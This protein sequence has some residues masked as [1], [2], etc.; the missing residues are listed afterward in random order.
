MDFLPVFLRDLLFTLSLFNLFIAVYLQFPIQIVRFLLGYCGIIGLKVLQVISGDYTNLEDF[1]IKRSINQT[2]AQQ[3]IDENK[4]GLRIVKLISAGT[5]GQAYLCLHEE[6]PVILKILNESVSSLQREI[7]ILNQ[8][9]GFLQKIIGL[10]INISVYTD[11]L[12]K[13]A[14]LIHEAENAIRFRKIY[15]KYDKIYIPEIIKYDET[16]IL[17]EYVQG[18]HFHKLQDEQT[19]R[20]AAVL[21]G[22]FLLHTYTKH[23]ITHGDLHVGNFLVDTVSDSVRLIILDFGIV[24]ENNA[25]AEIL[26]NFYNAISNVNRDTLLLS[27]K[28]FVEE[29]DTYGKEIDFETI[30]CDSVVEEFQTK[31]VDYNLDA[32]ISLMNKKVQQHNLIFKGNTMLFISQLSIVEHYYSN[33]SVQFRQFLHGTSSFMKNE[34][35]FVTEL[36]YFLFHF[37]NLVTVTQNGS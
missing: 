4:L 21:L 19:K 9:I 36:K 10:S 23:K 24:I 30:V 2:K 6:K 27:I 8:I 34:Y 35:F 11:Q 13:Q 31:C 14:N 20:Q 7:S 16:F 12:L 17:M 5:I 32:F 3:V 33:G 25:E 18:T 22:S 1:L 37:Y 26:Y 29:K 28:G 15:E